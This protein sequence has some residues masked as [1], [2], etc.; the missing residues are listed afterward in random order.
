[1]IST[2]ESRTHRRRKTGLLALLISV[3]ALT[4][5]AVGPIPVGA[6]HG[7]Q[8]HVAGGCHGPQVRPS[9]I[10]LA[11]ADG[12]TYFTRARWRGWGGKT[13]VARGV[14]NENNCT[15]DC[16]DGRFIRTHATITLH[17]IARCGG[18]LYYTR[19]RVSDNPSLSWY[20]QPSNPCGRV[21]G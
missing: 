19:A 1:V 6:F 10:V 13:A 4:A 16:V 21:L 9:Q 5:S 20:V 15:P 12:N 7:E 3:A 2:E 14:M 17:A 8:V 11:C 18:M